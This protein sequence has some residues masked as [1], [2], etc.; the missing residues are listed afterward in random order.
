MRR[1][2]LLGFAA[3]LAATASVQ[4]ADWPTKPIR[5]II[6]FGPGSATDVIPRIV[7]DKLGQQLGQQIVVENRGGAGGTLGEAAV[8]KADADGYMFLTT[9]SAHTIGPALYPNLSYDTARDFTAVG[10]MGSVPNVLIIAPSRGITIWSR[11]H[12]STGAGGSHPGSNA[13]L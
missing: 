12:A 1:V 9:S 11:R 6:P 13:S 7:F 4:A 2:V 5:T 8:A 3:V 10:A